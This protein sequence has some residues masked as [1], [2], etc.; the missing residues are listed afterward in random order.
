MKK[1]VWF[2]STNCLNKA[3]IPAGLLSHRSGLCRNRTVC[4]LLRSSHLLAQGGSQNEEEGEEEETPL[5]ASG[6]GQDEEEGEEEEE[7]TLG[8]ADDEWLLSSNPK[9]S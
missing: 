9:I 3:K 8:V 2:Q 5:L 1:A 4:H 6:G 7:A